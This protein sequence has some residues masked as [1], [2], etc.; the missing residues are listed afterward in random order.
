MTAWYRRAACAGLDVDLF[1]SNW[2]ADQAKAV[3]RGCE[4]TGACL[5]AA[6]EEEAGPYVSHGIRAGLEPHERDKI[7]RKAAASG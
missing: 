3:C 2:H 1:F 4:V 5:R 7:R 6:L